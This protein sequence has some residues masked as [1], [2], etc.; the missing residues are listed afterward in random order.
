MYMRPFYFAIYSDSEDNVEYLIKKT[1]PPFK[2]DK[3]KSYIE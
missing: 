3:N 1:F 2:I